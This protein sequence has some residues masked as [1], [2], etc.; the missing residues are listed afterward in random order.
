MKRKN[1]PDIEIVEMFLV[2]CGNDWSRTYMAQLSRGFDTDGEPVIYGRV[3]IDSYT[4]ICTGKTEEE[5]GEC[6][7]SIAELILNSDFSKLEEVKSDYGIIEIYH[8]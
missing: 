3:I 2:K 6:L 1:L 8:N 7:D 5:I 4:V